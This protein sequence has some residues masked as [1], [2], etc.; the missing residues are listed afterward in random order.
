MWTFQTI[1]RVPAPVYN[2]TKWWTLYCLDDNSARRCVKRQYLMTMSQRQY[3]QLFS[4][5]KREITSQ[6]R[7][8][9]SRPP[10]LIRGLNMSCLWKD[11]WYR[12]QGFYYSRKGVFNKQNWKGVFLFFKT[13]SFSLANSCICH[14]SIPERLLKIKNVQVVKF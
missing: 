14:S 1:S 8:M 5:K 10:L 7:I 13:F 12:G 9:N 3:F 2:A 6:V 11:V 4:W